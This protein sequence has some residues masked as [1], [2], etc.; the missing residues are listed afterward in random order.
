MPDVTE[1]ARDAYAMLVNRQREFFRSGATLDIA[2][3]L[4]QLRTLYRLL[5]R[6]EKDFFEA[7]KRDFGK[8][9]FETFGTELAL[10]KKDIRYLS[11]N[12]PRLMRPERVS[13]NAVSWPAKSR[14]YHVPYGVSLII[15]AWNY[16]L[17]LTLQPL[18]GAIA[19]GN[20][21]VLKP[22]ELA[23]HTAGLLHRLFQEA[24]NPEY[25]AV[26]EGG[27]EESKILLEQPFDYIFF[28]GSPAIG[29]KVMQAAAER[30]TPLTLELGGKSPCIVD[31]DADLDLSARRIVWGKFVNA[32][33]TCIAPDYLLA[34]HTVE[35]E[36]LE[37]IEKYIKQFYG[38]DPRNSPDYARLI[39]DHHFSRV[40]GLIDAT[41][42]YC[43]G[44]SDA[45]QRYIS[46]TVLRGS[47]WEDAAMQEEIFGPVLPVIS[48]NSLEEV[49]EKINQRPSPLALY[50]FS[51]ST[52]KLEQLQ[53]KVSYGGG[54]FNDTL[55]HFGNHHLPLGGVGN[56]GM[57]QYHG[58]YSFYAF[59][60]KKSMVLKSR[61][62]DIPL[63][64]P[65][66]EGKL[67][68]LRR[69]FKL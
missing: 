7:V 65:P 52:K 46:P 54:C 51:K 1:N 19:A 3:R 37:N 34:H 20:C 32:G 58:K 17:L 49:V 38:D 36:L 50:F 39:N 21:A 26:E 5:E 11:K 69:V 25:I 13:T 56:S 48:F 62:L 30:L 60:H 15:G 44:H 43:G 40:E 55:F 63:R 29:K 2:V 61:Y 12:L 24:Y 6:Y 18:A 41:K 68:W 4:Q 22:S 10:I 47:Q 67:K 23:G 33:Q 53:Q 66:Y 28:T 35:N 8:P 14:V 42:V 16:P 9:A 59:S 57:G 31:A 45:G 64:Y 27:A